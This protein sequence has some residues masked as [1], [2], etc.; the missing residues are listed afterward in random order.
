MAC[1]AVGKPEPKLTWTHAGKPVPQNGQR[2]SILPDGTLRIIDTQKSDSGTYI[3]TATNI[4]GIDRAVY[5]LKILVPPSRPSLHVTETTSSS[6]RLQWSIDDDGGTSDASKEVEA[7]TKGRAPEAPPPFQFVTT[8]SSQATL[9]LTQ[10][11][12]GGCPIIHFQVEYRRIGLS[13]WTTVGSKIPPSRTYAVGG[14]TAGHKYQVRVKAFN[15][16]GFT[17]KDYTVSTPAAGKAGFRETYREAGEGWNLMSKEHDLD[18]NSI[19]W[20]D[21]RILVPGLIS[22]LAVMLTVVTVCIC[23]RKKPLG[24]DIGNKAIPSEMCSAHGK[25]KGDLAE[26]YQIY[27]PIR[28]LPPTPPN[29]P[30]PSEARD[31]TGTAIRSFH[32]EPTK[33]RS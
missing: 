1:H 17:L 28:R 20:K 21:P 27:S 13:G 8:N 23:L 7:R 3:C 29:P 26:E 25:N 15:A 19:E 30:P 5:S 9:Y 4:H 33:W 12:D 11:E 24:K 31:S 16:A 14:L 32:R 22:I 6:I 10:W 2:Y 18:P